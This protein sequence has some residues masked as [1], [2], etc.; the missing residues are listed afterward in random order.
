MMEL[1]LL[2]RIS[3]EQQDYV[4]I[5]YT[6]IWKHHPDSWLRRGVC[7]APNRNIRADLT[8]EGC[9]VYTG[10]CDNVRV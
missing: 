4:A 9:V 6:D 3:S 10:S 2:H 1:T 7:N 8:G 5:S